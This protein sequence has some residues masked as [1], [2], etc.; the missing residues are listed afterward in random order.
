MIRFDN[1]SCF[2][3]NELLKVNNESEIKTY[4]NS[5]VCNKNTEIESYLKNNSLEFNKKHQAMTYLLF[6]KNKE[7]IAYFTLSVKPISIRSEQLSKNELKKLLRITEIDINDNSLNPAAYLIAQL[8]KK[9]NSVI[10]LDTI[11]RFVNYYINDAQ[12]ICGGVVEFLESENSD[13]LI[14][15]YQTKGFKIFN[16]RKSKS[17]EE[18]KLVQ[19]YRLI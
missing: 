5:F 13:K 18:R 3:L 12:D 16:I 19:M 4:L 11:F 6:D 15:L 10:N 8:G 17:G 1:I 9:D 14:A 2:S 7:V